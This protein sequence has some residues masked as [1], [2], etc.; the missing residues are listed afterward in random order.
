MVEYAMKTQACFL[1]EAAD[2]YDAMDRLHAYAYFLEGLLPVFE[3]PECRQ[4]HADGLESIQRVIDEVEPVFVRSDVY[5]QLLRA[6]LPSLGV[7]E[8]LTAFQAV[9]DDPR[10]DG[11][12]YF[13]RRDGKISP[14]VNPVFDSVRHAGARDANGRQYSVPEDADLIRIA[15]ASGNAELNRELIGRVAAMRPE[16]PL[17]V[18]AEF[19]PTFPSS[20]TGEWVP[21][22]VKRAYADNLAALQAAIGTRRVESAAIVRDPRVPPLGMD[23]AAREIAHGRLITYDEK[24]R[25]I[26]GIGWGAHLLRRAAA[27]AQSER[28]K[29]WLHRLAH[30]SD[31][32]IPVRARL[33]QAYGIVRGPRRGV[34][35]ES[36]MEGAAAS[37]GISVVIPSRNGRQLLATLLPGLEP[38]VERGEIIVSDNGSDDGTA[39]WLAAEYPRVVVIPGARPLSFARAV[40]TGIRAAR[41]A[42][43][44]LLNNDMVVEPGFVGGAQRGVHACARPVLRD[45]PDFLSAWSAARGNGE[46]RLAPREPARFSGALRRPDRWRRSDLGALRQ[47]RLFLV[48]YRETARTGRCERSVRARLCGGSRSRLP[49]VEARMAFGVLR[50]ARKWSIGIARQRRDTTREQELNY[51][52]ERNYLRFLIHAVG[53]PDLFRR[54]WLEAIRRLQLNAMDGDSAALAALRRVPRIGAQAAR[55]YPAHCRRRR[56]SRSVGATWPCFRDGREGNGKPV[57]IASPYLPFPLAH[58]GAVR[59]YNLMRR[60]AEAIRCCWRSRVNWRRRRMS[61][62]ICAVR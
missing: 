8:K 31:A 10:V 54:L 29:K 42:K 28:T 12:F 16:L 47:R 38:Q 56:F 59:M 33:E 3:R 9:S 26:R 55:Q 45:R 4:A 62:S 19:E 30:P 43:T 24:L 34:R 1:R 2:P 46:S 22:H 50:R 7:A 21:W 60:A 49:G 44:L 14:Q 48:R 57:V 13:G 52:L 32:E 58:G 11:G 39:E 23:R 27:Q 36:P 17:V 53:S 6:G 51:F 15:F 18:V 35:Q 41:F 61:S 37:E 20:R 25:V 5:A 40:N